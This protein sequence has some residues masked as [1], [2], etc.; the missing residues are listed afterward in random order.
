M[1]SVLTSTS[2]IPLVDPELQLFLEV[3]PEDHF[4]RRL[5]QAIDFE[6]FRPILESAYRG[7][8]RPPLDSVF[9]MKLELLAR[10]HR[11]SDREVIAAVRFNIAFRLFLGISLKSPLPH[12]TLLTYFRQRLGTQRVQQVFDALVGQARGLGLVKDRLRLKDATH[13]IANIAV[14]STI[15]LVAEVRDQLLEALRPFV[16]A[17]VAEEEER[18]ESIRFATEDAK[19]EERLVQRVSQLRGVL[20]W[21]DDLPQQA[22]FAA[23]GVAVREKLLAALTLAHKVLADRDDPEAGDKVISAHDADAR[24]GM[25][26]DFYEGYLLDVAMDADSELLT[27]VNVLPANGNEGAD[28]VHLIRQ[29]EQAHGNDVQA[30]SIDGAGYRGELLREL[31]DPEGLNLEVFVPPAER[32]IPLTVFGPDQF[33]LGEDGKTLT[34]PAGQ[35]THYH[36]RNRIDTGVIFRFSKKQ[37]SGCPLR[38]ECLEKETTQY[39]SVCKNDYQAEYEAAQAKA[40]TPAYAATRKEHPAI[41]RKLSELVRRH[42]MR[43]ARYRGLAKVLAQGLLTGLVVNLKR[44][45]RLLFAPGPMGKGSVRAEVVAAS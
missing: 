2:L 30:V 42:D 43:H 45:V 17:R 32:R 4:L 22:C 20:A 27:A 29:E 24:R 37:C 19:D 28:A 9:M 39:R 16:A 25:H 12:H 18:S 44:I 41:E 11:L 7:F 38:K 1:F 31:T 3:V 10:Q 5:L 40:K 14:P 23:A 21:A 8:G 15:R 13:I 35:T 36:Q 6:G 34:C 26:G 33:V